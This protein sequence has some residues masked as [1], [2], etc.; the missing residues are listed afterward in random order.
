[1]ENLLFRKSRNII[2]HSNSEADKNSE[3]YKARMLRNFFTKN[4][5]VFSKKELLRLRSKAINCGVWFRA[6]NRV[7]RALVYL[8]IKVASRVRSAVLAKALC[9][10]VRK[11]EDAMKSKVLQTTRI[12]G[13]QLAHKLSLF[14]QKWGN[15]SARNWVYDASF[16]RFLAIMYINNSGRFKV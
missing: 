15:I 8:T 2:L 10:I 5:R 13:F 6:L 12:F 16:A 9:S 3:A 11:L 4:F 1:M 14:A 7:D